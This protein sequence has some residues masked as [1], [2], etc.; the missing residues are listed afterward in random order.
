MALEL[1]G[2]ITNP[3]RIYT[4]VDRSC[5]GAVGI[6]AGTTSGTDKTA[7]VVA[8]ADDDACNTEANMDKKEY[9]YEK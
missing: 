2:R 9:Q 5:T 8:A 7:A 6:G 1:P 3:L 4:V